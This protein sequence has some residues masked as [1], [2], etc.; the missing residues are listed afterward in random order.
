MASRG[1]YR[2]RPAPRPLPRPAP[3]HPVDFIDCNGRFRRLVVACM[4]HCP[5]GEH[6]C[7]NFTEFFEKNRIRPADYYNQDGVGNEVM[8]RIVFDCDRCNKKDIDEVFS[9][10]QDGFAA[11]GHLLSQE[12][13]EAMFK[14]KGFHFEGVGEAVSFLLGLMEERFGWIHLCAKCFDRAINWSARFLKVKPFIT[15]ETVKEQEKKAA[16]TQEKSTAKSTQKKRR[17]TKR[18]PAKSTRRAK[19]P[20]ANGDARTAAQA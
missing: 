16:K 14:A 10:Y 20:R 19:K 2:I 12:E 4:H 1:L 13:L 8:R 18:P 11:D 9:R 6:F 3:D 15:A 5:F 17:T 7:S